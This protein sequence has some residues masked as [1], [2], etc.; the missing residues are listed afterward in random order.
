MASIAR[1]VYRTLKSNKVCQPFE[2]EVQLGKGPIVCVPRKIKDASRR[3]YSRFIRYKGIAPDEN[4]L[5][6]AA[7]VG[8]A[9]AVRLFLEAMQNEKDTDARNYFL[10]DTKDISDL[11]DLDVVMLS[12][13]YRS[14]E[15]L[16]VLLQ[17]KKILSF[18]RILKTKELSALDIYFSVLQWSLRKQPFEFKFEIPTKLQVEYSLRVD[19][20]FNYSDQKAELEVLLELAKQNR[21]EVAGREKT[22][23]RVQELAVVIR[24]MYPNTF[25]GINQIMDQIAKDVTGKFEVCL[26]REKIDL[27]KGRRSPVAEIFSEKP[28]E[29]DPRLENI[30]KLSNLRRQTSYEEK[31]ECREKKERLMKQIKEEKIK[32]KKVENELKELG[33]CGE[34]KKEAKSKKKKTLNPKEYDRMYKVLLF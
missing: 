7:M 2:I 33:S 19:K 30:L 24:L 15:V 23:Q 18:D 21:C 9:D 5:L 26:S 31:K 8:D 34:P 20:P 22:Y 4:P 17:Y 28:G 32:L 27:R 3:T 25:D 16:G 13:F 6:L 12:A 11:P 14:Y 10:M 1:K 29:I